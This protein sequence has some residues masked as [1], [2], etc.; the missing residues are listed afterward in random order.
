LAS[1]DLRLIEQTLDHLLEN[2]MKYSAPGELIDIT[3][4]QEAAQHN[5]LIRVRDHGVGIPA[6]RRERI[7]SQFG[8][9]DTPTHLAGTGLSLYL[10]RQFI[11][12]HGGR[13]GVGA[14]RGS[15]ATVWFT[16]PLASDVMPDVMPDVMVSPTR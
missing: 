2:A 7:F 8:G 12:R 10:C 13:I 1:V 16:L 5:A 14:T 3:V 9:E 6:D 4:R 15:G 11:E